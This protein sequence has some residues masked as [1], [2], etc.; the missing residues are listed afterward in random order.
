MKKT[1]ATI[2]AAVFA[3]SL[4]A[5]QPLEAQ[6]EMCPD[7]ISDLVVE[8]KKSI[9]LVDMSTFQQSLDEK[10]YDLVIDVREPSEYDAGHVAGAINIPRGVIEFMIWTNVG[11]P[12]STDKG[13]NICLYCNTG[14]RASLSGKSLKELG[15]TNVTVVDMRLP[16]WIEAGFPIEESS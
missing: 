1:L 11:F 6:E 8:A 9:R 5:S 12:D 13:R 14:G 4:F 3:T 2:A 10:N 16:D 7:I 15:F